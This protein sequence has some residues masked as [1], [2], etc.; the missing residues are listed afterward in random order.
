M[1]RS[2]LL[3]LP[4]RPRG[5]LGASAGTRVLYFNFVMSCRDSFALAQVSAYSVQTADQLC[6]PKINDLLRGSPNNCG[7]QR[8]KPGSS[9]GCL[10]RLLLYFEARY[11]LNTGKIKR[12]LHHF[13]LF[14]TI[15]TSAR[16]QN[17]CS[18]LNKVKTKIHCCVSGLLAVGF[19]LCHSYH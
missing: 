19:K 11:P 1:F 7:A 16:F 3:C 6:W 14:Y 4:R 12:V 18:S 17:C 5:H 2:C 9:G 13:P 15:C 8:V 10:Q